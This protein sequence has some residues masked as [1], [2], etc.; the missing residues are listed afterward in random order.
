M[1]I[2]YLT[3]ANY[4]QSTPNK[5]DDDTHKSIKGAG[6]EFLTKLS[7]AQQKTGEN[8]QLRPTSL[9][10]SQSNILTSRIAASLADVEYIA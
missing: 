8:S 10:E 1:S 5:G 9:G 7:S 4:H 6:K 3:N 2:C